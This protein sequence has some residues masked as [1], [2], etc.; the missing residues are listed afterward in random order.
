MVVPLTLTGSSG[1]V[2]GASGEAPAS[3]GSF[4]VRGSRKQSMMR[5]LMVIVSSISVEADVAVRT[6]RGRGCGLSDCHAASFDG[7][8]LTVGADFD[9]F[10]GGDRGSRGHGHN[11]PA[12]AE[13]RHRVA[14]SLV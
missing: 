6:F 13:Q 8:R 14:F 11:E 9:L 12:S 10:G 2:T 3:S 1:Y 5:C 4:P 7:D